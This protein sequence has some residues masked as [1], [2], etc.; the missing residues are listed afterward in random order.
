MAS[1][2]TIHVPGVS[3]GPPKA[4]GWCWGGAVGARVVR[5]SRPWEESIW[6][7]MGSATTLAA[8]RM[9][10]I[11]RIPPIRAT[12]CRHWSARSNAHRS[13]NVSVKSTK[14]VKMR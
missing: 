12:S 10:I 3:D 7:I 14:A 5:V 1:T 4:D 2:R 9:P 13:L 11:S 8:C 6:P